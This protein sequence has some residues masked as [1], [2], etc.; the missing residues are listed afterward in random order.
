MANK[1]T[2]SYLS[3]FCQ[4]DYGIMTG[5]EILL[6]ILSIFQKGYKIMYQDP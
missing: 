3:V 6:I 1:L 5:G 4:Y 2:G